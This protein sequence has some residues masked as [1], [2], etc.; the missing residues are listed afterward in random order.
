MSPGCPVQF[1]RPIRVQRQRVLKAGELERALDLAARQ[2]GTGG[3]VLIL[4]DAET[5]CPRELAPN[6]LRR[7]R[8]ARGDRDIR[9]VLA[10]AEYEAWFLAAAD[11][12]AGQ[13]GIRASTEPPD[14]AEAVTGAKGMV[15]GAHAAGSKLPRD[16]SSAGAHRDLRFGRGALRA[17]VRQVVAGRERAAGDC[18]ASRLMVVVVW[19][20]PEDLR[21]DRPPQS[22]ALE[23]R[24]DALEQ[25]QPMS[26]LTGRVCP[27][28]GCL[29][30]FDSRALQT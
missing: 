17:F 26:D 16:A 5:D 22:G 18:R 9:V 25:A 15:E 23:S 14:D 1:V 30:G 21:R 4:L 3:C 20:P 27:R 28:G 2:A 8:E 24:G 7:A 10:K 12:I 29:A 13:H 6:L 19:S 11:S